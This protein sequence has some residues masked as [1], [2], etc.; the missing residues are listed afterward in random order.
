MSQGY[1]HPCHCHYGM[2]QG[3]TTMYECA[4]LGCELCLE[5]LT[6]EMEMELAQQQQQEEQ[7][8]HVDKSTNGG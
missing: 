3:A 8:G 1:Y 7:D 5:V 2:T 4:S 6:E